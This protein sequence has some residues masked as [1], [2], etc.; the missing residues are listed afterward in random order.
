MKKMIYRTCEYVNDYKQ[1]FVYEEP[2]YKYNAISNELEIV[3]KINNFDMIQS[4]KDCALDN[5]L[6]RFMG[7]DIDKDVDLSDFFNKSNL[8]ERDTRSDLEILQSYYE[9]VEEL[10]QKFNIS[11]YVDTADVYAVIQDN[12]QKSNAKKEEN[13]NAKKIEEKN[14]Q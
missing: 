4:Y 13:E 1:S 11:D 12:I 8:Y 6:D 3:G 10:R 9:Q 14:S 7:D 2:E 5:I